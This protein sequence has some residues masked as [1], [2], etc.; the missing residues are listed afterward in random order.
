MTFVCDKCRAETNIPESFITRRKSFR[1]TVRTE[2]PRCHS[3]SQLSGLRIRL[4]WS[5][6]IG[7]IGLI[8]LR[9]APE[10][11]T[12]WILLNLF[13][14]DVFLI[15][16]I[17]PHEFGHA[18][19]AQWLGLRV[20]RVYIGFG[21]TL[22][23]ANIF[24]F[25]TEFKS[26]PLGGLTLAT[27]RD[28]TRFR[29][30]Q[31]A[32]IVAGPFASVLLGGIAL[33]FVPFHE[34]LDFGRIGL[35][36]VPGQVFLY[37]NLV[38][39][40][41]NLWPHTFNSPIGKIANDGKL[42][43]RTLFIKSDAIND[44][45]AARFAM[46]ATNCHEKHQYANALAWIEQGLAHFPENFL[47]LNWRGVLLIDCKDFEAARDCFAKLLGRQVNPPAVRALML[48]NI[49]YVDV[50]L[51]GV[52]RV[53]E[54]DRYSQEAMSLIGW[55]PPVKGTRGTTLIELGQIEDGLR[56][57]RESMRQNDDPGGKAQNAC[58]IS[59]GEARRG[60]L[61]ESLKY[62]EEARRLVS[63][64]FLIDRAEAALRKASIQSPR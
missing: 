13:L 31:L 18:C 39:L 50:L 32:F 33:L 64:C 11:P 42:L 29:L 26:V 15:A 44:L 17:L 3:E 57:L 34:V 51:G 35:G 37:A 8:F 22:F 20:F 46:E 58:F 2:C 21:R 7:L 62:L 40:V 5:A 48:N 45:L 60:N 54:A 4:L 16:T 56:L 43:W 59:M 36:L 47:L 49:A 61:S 9:V 30:K 28:A 55:M 12:G 24:G 27:P 14:F 10:E 23:T 63:N 6:V 52:D 19:V 1:R 41:Q 25:H 53:A 38:V